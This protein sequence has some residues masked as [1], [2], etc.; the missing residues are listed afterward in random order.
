M[1]TTV[2]QLPN[3]GK[4][5]AA[6][7]DKLVEHVQRA[8][9]DLV[10]L[11]E[12]GLSTWLAASNDVDQSLWL[13]GIAE[14]EH[15]IERF[16]ELAPA[17]VVGSRPT[18]IAD[19]NYNQGF[20]WGAEDGL[21]T[22]HTK[23]YLP[24]EPEFWE[25]TWYRRS[26]EKRFDTFQIGPTTAGMVLC[27]DMWFTEHARGYARAGADLLLCPRA[28]PAGSADIWVAGGRVAAVMSGAFCLSS[29]HAGRYPGVHMAGVGWII[30]PDGEVLGLTSDEQP[31]LTLEIDLEQAR[32]AKLVYPRYVLE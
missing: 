9:S 10:V 12:L 20:T 5:L 13:A 21:H 1:K 4:Q 19:C 22:V 26:P 18:L 8:G 2:C 29:N 32:A 24:D 6:D 27:T 25:A 28:T 30:D 15:W 31:F 14:H 3:H 17:T 11:P 16:V 23:Y 7:W